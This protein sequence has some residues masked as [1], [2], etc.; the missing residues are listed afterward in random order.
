[1]SVF[2]TDVEYIIFCIFYV[3]Q[4]SL[5][6]EI[7]YRFHYHHKSLLNT[8]FNFRPCGFQGLVPL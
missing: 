4:T 8:Y 5:L 1:M 7:F 6:S 3:R 2:D